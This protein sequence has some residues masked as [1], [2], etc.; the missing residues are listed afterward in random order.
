MELGCLLVS[1]RLASQTA[2]WLVERRVSIAMRLPVS[3]QVAQ[4]VYASCTLLRNLARGRATAAIAQIMHAPMS[5][6]D[7]ANCICM[8]HRSNNVSKA[9]VEKTALQSK[10]QTT[11]L[12]R[13]R[14]D[15]VTG[16]FQRQQ[17][18]ECLFRPNL[19]MGYVYSNPVGPLAL[20]AAQ[21]FEA[22]A[23]GDPFD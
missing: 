17:R 21:G 15:C 8:N 3:I 19:G 18:R 9:C 10:D 6:Y 20:A 1:S 14:A 11:G 23:V 2:R 5:N 13:T 22:V 16:S 12:K 7:I 4:E